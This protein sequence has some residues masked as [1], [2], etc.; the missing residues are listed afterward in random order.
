MR[1]E[2]LN[3][4]CIKKFLWIDSDAF[5]MSNTNNLQGT[6][7]SHRIE[8]EENVWK[9]FYFALKICSYRLH[10][11]LN[12]AFKR[13]NKD[14]IVF[15]SHDTCKTKFSCKHFYYAEKYLCYLCKLSMEKPTEQVDRNLST[16]PF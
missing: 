14:A 6:V 8:R 12:S 16:Q 2:K 1:R 7:M 11:A 13:K 4:N 3:K 10:R 9:A 15:P 5:P